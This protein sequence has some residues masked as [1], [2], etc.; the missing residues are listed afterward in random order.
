MADHAD[1][2]TSS[3]LSALEEIRAT[4][5]AGAALYVSTAQASAAAIADT[6]ALI[7]CAFREGRKLLLCG[8]GGSAADCQHM[9]AEL[10]G[11]LTPE[12]DRPGLPAIAITTDSSFLTAHANDRGFEGVFARQIQALGRTGDVL[13]A[14]TTSGRSA[15]VLRAI[16]E[17]RRQ[18]MSVVV[19]TGAGGPAAEVADVGITVPSTDTQLVQQ[20]H[21]AV[22]H[23]ICFLVERQL[24]PQ[25]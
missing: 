19:L 18:G 4:L 9:A 22:E 8:N 12:T 24:H 25:D 10:V 1:P 5:G 11:R 7:A 15:N 14:I 23:L 16:Q 20:V 21:V 17:A 6:A 2:G 3:R 13:L